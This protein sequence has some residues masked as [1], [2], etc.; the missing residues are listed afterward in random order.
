MACLSF[1]GTRGLCQNNRRLRNFGTV[2]IEYLCVLLW[3]V[4]GRCIM[5]TI[6]KKKKA[7]VP[8][9]NFRR[10]SFHSSHFLI[11]WLPAS[12]GLSGLPG[13]APTPFLTPSPAVLLLAQATPPTLASFFSLCE[14]STPPALGLSHFWFPLRGILFP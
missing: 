7:G 10:K 5:M 14:L 1:Y 13:L 3:G 6:K 12:C 2:R 11:H 8:R 9:I 4:V